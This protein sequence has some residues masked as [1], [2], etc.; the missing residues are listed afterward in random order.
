[1]L[2]SSEEK[3]ELIA[4][5]TASITS[6]TTLVDADTL[7]FTPT[8]SFHIN[9]RGIPVLRF[10]LPP[11]ELTITVQTSDGR[12]AYT[13][14][15]EKRCSGNS[16]LSNAQGTAVISTTYFFGVGKDPVLK[17]VDVGRE[18]ATPIKTVSKWTSRAQTFLLPDNRTFTWSYERAV[19][20]G[21]E[22]KKG[23]A[24][25]LSMDGKRI[26]AL[27]RNDNTRTLG[28]KSCS[29]G[30]GGELVLG[31]EVDG[32]EKTSLSEPVVVASCLLMLKKEVDRRRLV[33]AMAIG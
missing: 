32:N 17:R 33:Q 1:A 4:A 15:R 11:S 9:T 16:T 18:D 25:V 12:I 23:T 6:V 3:K 5:E 29:A 13:S 20:F 31:Q 2:L 27:I 28:S 14:T 24:L 21:G 30:N 10:P 26:A 8:K 19:G 7:P 22:G